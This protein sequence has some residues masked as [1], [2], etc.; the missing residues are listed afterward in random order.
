M[1]T[2]TNDTRI[3]ALLW[4]TDYR[5][6]SD[7]AFGTAVTITYSFMTT[8]P[9]D[10]SAT[11][12]NGFSAMTAAQQEM[13][14]S[15]LAAWAEVANIT[16]VETTASDADIQFGMNVQSGSSGYTVSWGEAADIYINSG[17]WGGGSDWDEFV[18]IHE[19]GHAL[20]LKHP[21]NYDAGGGSTPGPYLSSSED[22][23]SYTVMSYYTLF[24]GLLPSTPMLYDL[25]AIQYLYGANTAT[26]SG[27][28][29][30]RFDGSDQATI[31]DGGGND[32]LDASALGSGVALDLREGSFSSFGTSGNIAIGYGVTIENATGSGFDDSLTGNDAA[33]LLSGLAGNDSIT[34][35]TGDTVDGG[36]DSDAVTLSATASLWV[37]NVETVNGS[38]GGDLI[39]LTGASTVTV[40]AVDTIHGSSGGDWVTLADS[41]PVLLS[42]I[43]TLLGSSGGDSVLL[44]N[45]TSSITM[46]A[47]ETLTGG[48]DGTW[49]TLGDRGGTVTLSAIETVLGGAGGDAVIL[50]GSGGTISMAAIETVTGSAGLDAVSTGARGGS[51]TVSAVET[52]T[53]G[54]GADWITLGTAAT[55]QLSG[56]ETLLGSADADRVT[57]SGG[58]SVIM[59]AIETV[60]GSSGGDWLTLGDR[61]GTIAVSGV[62]T[63]CGGNGADMVRLG[64]GGNTVTMAAV[65]TVAGGSGGDRLTLGDRGGTVTLQGIES[66]Q[67]GSGA[68]T[69]ILSADTVTTLVVTSADSG[70][71]TVYGFRTDIDRLTFDGSLLQAVD[72]NGDGSLSVTWRG[73]GAVT[74][75]D[76]VIRLTTTVP[77]L[78]D[79]DYRAFSYALGPLSADMAG[80]SLLV[81]ASDGT[82][83]GLYLITVDAQPR[84]TASEVTLLV[85]F[86]GAVLSGG[87]AT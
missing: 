19:I 33:N 51:V 27:D 64:D 63:L 76:E 71:D 36:A 87:E 44:E 32:T 46:A 25:L 40:A 62:E 54:S 9:D 66:V 83:T 74:S 5:M 2:I 23:T 43:E 35:G 13:T 57:L 12:A 69:L 16:F 18:L 75:G 8:L 26:G 53:G 10:A 72:S 29:A 85:R 31:W 67:G 11:D 28:T 39:T 30:Y 84:V 59:A 65:E 50:G 56:V 15:A 86:E 82:S 60:T 70:G 80:R 37:T 77:L 58:G 73:T 14:R 79:T 42:S 78:A 47:V 21:G 45:G 1:A 6:N 7:S 48:S 3:D 24:T 61:G 34:A 20:G 68:D 52:L 4:G 38:F 55:I 41:T 81:I 17:N 22:N 49:V